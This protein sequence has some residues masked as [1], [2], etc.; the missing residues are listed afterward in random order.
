MYIEADDVIFPPF[1]RIIDIDC[2]IWNFA[3]A[4]QYHRKC[5]KTQ[6]PCCW[7]NWKPAFHNT[8]YIHSLGVQC[9]GFS[10]KFML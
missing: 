6:I 10:I 5:G 9:F 1:D 8:I 2:C 3:V 7:S 4:Y